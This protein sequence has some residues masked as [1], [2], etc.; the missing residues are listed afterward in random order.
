LWV[1]PGWL[2]NGAADAV[3][4]FRV[5]S[6]DGDGVLFNVRS[7]FNPVGAAERYGRQCDRARFDPAYRTKTK[8]KDIYSATQNR[9]QRVQTATHSGAN[10]WYSWIA[11]ANGLVRIRS[12]APASV[13]T[14]GNFHPIGSTFKYDLEVYFD[15]GAP[16][17]GVFDT[18]TAQ[19]AGG[20]NDG[21]SQERTFYAI[22]DVVYFIEI[23][24]DNNTN[25]AGRGFF[26]LHN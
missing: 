5:T 16:K 20:F 23:G 4:Y 26:R 18:T 25:T 12:I 11:P 7:T 8:A 1:L 24:G 13:A 21:G 17:D 2:I 10:V 19:T 15:T 14:T 9:S 3:Y 22:K 6:T